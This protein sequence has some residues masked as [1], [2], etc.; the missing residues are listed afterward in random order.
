[1]LVDD[2]GSDQ[3]EFLG[4]DRD[5][6]LVGAG[7]QIQQLALMGR[8]LVE[9]VHAGADQLAGIEAREHLAQLGFGLAQHFLQGRIH[10]H[11]VVVGRRPT[12]RST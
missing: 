3:V 9:H 2:G 7:E 11:D 10:V 6:G 8:V 12:S 1:M 4:A 5:V